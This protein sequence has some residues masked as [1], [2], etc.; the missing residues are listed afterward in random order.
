MRG[1]ATAMP[2]RLVYWF[3][4]SLQASSKSIS[5]PS[6][7]QPTNKTVCLIL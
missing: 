3:G 4:Y 6:V 2:C 7:F 5:G 1:V